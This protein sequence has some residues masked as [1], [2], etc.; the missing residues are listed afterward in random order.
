MGFCVSLLIVPTFCVK[1]K[2]K[3]VQRVK[4]FDPYDKIV[5]LKEDR[6]FKAET[7]KAPLV[8]AYFYTPK[9]MSCPQ[10]TQK[11]EEVVKKLKDVQEVHFVKVDAHEF[12]VSQSHF[13]RG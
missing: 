10:F 4:K 13:S 8:V 9:C 7:L 11:F 12:K 3:A 2:S 6:M 1:K 5:E